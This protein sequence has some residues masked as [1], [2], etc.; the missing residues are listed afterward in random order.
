MGK[1]MASLRRCN[2]R[3]PVLMLF[4]AGNI[5]EGK[6]LAGVECRVWVRRRG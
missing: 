4:E 1:A 3:N 6:V 2:G 5:R